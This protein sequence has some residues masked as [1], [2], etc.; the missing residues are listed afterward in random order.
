MRLGERFKE[1]KRFFCAVFFHEMSWM[2]SGTEL[3]QF[4]KVFLPTVFLFFYA[5]GFCN[6]L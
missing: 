2:R 5:E 1:K 3:S 6:W 4:L